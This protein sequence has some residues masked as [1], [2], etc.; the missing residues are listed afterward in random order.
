M[1]EMESIQGERSIFN[2]SAD[3]WPD[4]A[5]TKA[6]LQVAATAAMHCQAEWWTH[7]PPPVPTFLL[8]ENLPSKR[9]AP[10]DSMQP[11]TA[12]TKKHHRLLKD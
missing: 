8:A 7:P 12:N 4:P 9:I 1:P 10:T 6:F 2:A 11:K 3:K 5:L